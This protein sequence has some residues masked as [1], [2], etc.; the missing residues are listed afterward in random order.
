MIQLQITRTGKSYSPKAKWTCFDE[1]TK[2][3]PDM[4]TVRE[5]LRK[6][7]G[8]A[9]RV[10]MFTDT[11]DGKTLRTGWVIGFRN[12]DL[13]HYPV[14]KWIQ[15]DWIHVREIKEIDLNEFEE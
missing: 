1:E 5:W 8:N 10:P 3:F 15:Q 6:E 13:S 4:K 14:N 11:K 7:Y 12:A 9:K 2:N